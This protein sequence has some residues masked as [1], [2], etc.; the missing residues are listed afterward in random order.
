MSDL[1][2]SGQITRNNALN[3]LSQP[4]LPPDLV[5]KDRKYLLEKFELTDIQ[6]EE[7]INSKHKSFRNYSNNYN[8]VQFVRNAVNLLRKYDLYPK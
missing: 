5:K 6:F 3:E 7:I 2:N 8:W 4:P 1:I